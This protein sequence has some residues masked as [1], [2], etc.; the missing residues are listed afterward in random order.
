MD[1]GSILIAVHDRAMR[2]MIFRV[3]MRHSGKIRC[4]ST[5]GKAISEIETF[6]PDLMIISTELPPSGG[7]TLVSRVKS[8]YKPAPG[9]L[10]V[11]SELTDDTESVGFPC[12]ALLPLPI[13]PDELAKRIAAFR[14]PMA[15]EARPGLRLVASAV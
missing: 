15:A 11:T 1:I 10:F 8:R 4:A 7:L 9:F 13:D 6:R 14:S 12:D 2:D 3:L 5:V